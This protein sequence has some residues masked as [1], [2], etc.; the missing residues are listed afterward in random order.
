MHMQT[1]KK[2]SLTSLFIL[3]LVST[4]LIKR[5][6][7]SPAG[8][9]FLI[10]IWLRGRASN[11]SGQ[12]KDVKSFH[13]ANDT[14]VKSIYLFSGINTERMLSSLQPPRPRILKQ[15]SFFFLFYLSSFCFQRFKGRTWEA[16]SAA[17]TFRVS[18]WTGQEKQQTKVI[19]LQ[20]SAP[21]RKGDELQQ[22][23]RW[24]F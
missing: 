7:L 18:E 2:V 10:P 15:C 13:S 22:K 8:L 14:G 11:H 24:Q 23:I 21:A 16:T 6:L 17:G 9:R 1:P 20:Y 12:Y 3:C 4:T 5:A 19:F